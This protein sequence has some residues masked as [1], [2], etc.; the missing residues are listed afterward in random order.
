MLTASSYRSAVEAA[1]VLFFPPRLA[2]DRDFNHLGEV[3]PDLRRL[4]NA[5]VVDRLF[6][7]LPVAEA[8]VQGNDVAVA[9][10]HWSAGVLVNDGITLGVPLAAGLFGLPWATVSPFIFCTWPVSG[11]PPPF[12]GLPRR[13]GHA[14][15]LTARAGW[16]LS[17]LRAASAT[18]R[19]SSL[20]RAWHAERRVSSA[21]VAGCSPLLYLYPGGP[22]L[23][24]PG[25]TLPRC[26]QGVG[27]LVH[28]PALG[29]HAAPVGQRRIFVTEGMTHT[30]SGLLTLAVEAM[31][32]W[33][34]ELLVAGGSIRSE[35]LQGVGPP[36]VRVVGHVRYSE[37][38][39]G[40]SLL[41]TNGGAG[42]L[43]AA[44]QAGV[45]SL[46]LP[47]GLDKAEAAGRVA[48]TGAGVRLPPAHRCTPR[49]LRATAEHVMS[50]PSYRER[51][52][53]V[54]RSLLALGGATRAAALLEDLAV[55][56]SCADKS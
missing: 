15:L 25:A 41:I 50:S 36:H 30:G 32:G 16:Q 54:G 1:G 13:D 23:E 52:V 9:A 46:I 53:E 48:A 56:Q 7:D 12:W 3:L 17:R 37:A 51:A 42:S 47:A 34:G 33:R 24:S 11:Q 14:G 49:S 44:L 45:P 19:W 22:A 39:A 31:Q 8:A 27:P 29:E 28:E 5:E 26:V 20:A 2:S 55:T 21:R 43:L 4:P 38:L 40:A 18:H 35:Q 6:V 10:K